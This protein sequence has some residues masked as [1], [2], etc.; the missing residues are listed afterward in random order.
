MAEVMYSWM[1]SGVAPQ[2]T[3]H[4]L[5]RLILGAPRKLIAI[6]EKA[7]SELIESLSRPE[8]STSEILSSSWNAM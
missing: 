8:S 4:A 2:L 6:L 5:L 3:V 1:G 7:G